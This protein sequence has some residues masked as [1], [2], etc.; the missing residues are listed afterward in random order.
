MLRY[1]I[2]GILYLPLF[3]LTWGFSFLIA[4]IIAV[5]ILSVFGPFMIFYV[6]F[7]WWKI[8]I[9]LLLVSGV[10]VTVALLIT[11]AQHRQIETNRPR[12]AV[13]RPYRD[14][15]REQEPR[16]PLLDYLVRR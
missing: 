2:R 8:F 15:V 6:L 11:R 5:A 4:L 13:P 9:I 7:S 14:A 12:L 3:L 1:V 16:S 10:A